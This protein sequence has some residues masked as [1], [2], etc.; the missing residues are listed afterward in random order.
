MLRSEN[1]QLDTE[2]VRWGEKVKEGLGHRKTERAK[3][4][5]GEEG[6]LGEEKRGC[7]EN[8]RRAS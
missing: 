5:A 4:E 3:E 2:K 6:E 7:I 1:K 8:E